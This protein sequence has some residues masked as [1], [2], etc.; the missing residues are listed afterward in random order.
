M[1]NKQESIKEVPY[2]RI[3][4]KGSEFYIKDD[5]TLIAHW[6]GIYYKLIRI[7]YIEDAEYMKTRI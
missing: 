1:R 5:N 6:H 4:K 2:G 7:S 3:H